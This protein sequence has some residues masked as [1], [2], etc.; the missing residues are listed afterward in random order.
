MPRKPID[1]RPVL[2]RVSAN[3]Y[4]DMVVAATEPA[5]VAPEFTERS[6]ALLTSWQ[7]TR[8]NRSLKTGPLPPALVFSDSGLEFA[9]CLLGS[10][11]ESD[12][13]V[14]FTVERAFPV[15]AIR[16]DDWVEQ[17]QLSPVLIGDLATALDTGLRVIGD[18]HSHPYVYANPSE[19]VRRKYFAPS[20]SDRK[21]LPFKGY[22]ISIVVTVSF[23]DKR[24]KRHVNQPGPH[25]QVRV[26]DF[27]V[28]T[29][30][31]IGGSK[32]KSATD[33]I[34]HV[35]PIRSAKERIAAAA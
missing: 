17:S 29:C 31:Y 35:M 19:I 10:K 12:D 6:I 14:V 2:V 34:L 8:K 30:A 9:G 25:H 16:A 15:T 28:W 3:A 11:S 4:L 27:E 23:A 32:T 20:A 5:I 13:E 26:G 18:V 7:R 1:R 22:E 33:V 24:R 21:G